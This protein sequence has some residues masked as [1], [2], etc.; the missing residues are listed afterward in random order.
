MENGSYNKYLT[1]L[2]NCEDGKKLFA[3]RLELHKETGKDWVLGLITS[4]ERNDIIYS[5]LKREYPASF[6]ILV[7]AYPSL[8][9]Y[10]V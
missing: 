8:A 2:N 7:Q 6:R 5:T 10:V 9:R 1:E 3:R 4:A